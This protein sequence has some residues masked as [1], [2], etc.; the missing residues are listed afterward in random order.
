MRAQHQPVADRGT[1]AA[2][3]A[4]VQAEVELKRLRERRAPGRLGTEGQQPPRCPL[5]AP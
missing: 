1:A 3:A 2:S 5:T 4:G